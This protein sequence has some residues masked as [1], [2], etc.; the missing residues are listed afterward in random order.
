MGRPSLKA[1]NGPLPPWLAWI[2]VEVC[3]RQCN[4]SPCHGGKLLSSLFSRGFRRPRAGHNSWFARGCR[5]E[6][7]ASDGLFIGRHSA[8]GCSPWRLCAAQETH[9]GLYV[10][11]LHVVGVVTVHT[12]GTM[13]TF[14]R[15]PAD[16]KFDKAAAAALAPGL[17]KLS[18]L[19]S[20]DLTCECARFIACAPYST[21]WTEFGV[22]SP[23]SCL[24]PLTWRCRHRAHRRS[25][26]G[27]GTSHLKA[28]GAEDNVLGT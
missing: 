20:L 2:S 13:F 21:T 12:D 16:N 18:Q 8:A 23:C 9:M 10:E 25:V 4:T 5:N 27:L 19:Q 15:A 11:H 3:T 22:I 6:A 28:G 1:S 24:H 7:G 14:C 26:G 17:A